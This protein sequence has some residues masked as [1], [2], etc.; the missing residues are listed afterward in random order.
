[1]K[2]PIFETRFSEEIVQEFP[3]K[4]FRRRRWPLYVAGSVII[5]VILLGIAWWQ[6]EK[7]VSMLW[8]SEKLQ[9]S[10]EQ[11]LGTEPLELFGGGGRGKTILLIGADRRSG[12]EEKWGRSDTIIVARILPQERAISLLSLPRDLQVEI[13]GYGFDKINAAYSLG[14]P[15][16]LIETVRN[17]VGSPIDHYVE[18][19]FDGFA[20]MVRETDGVYLPVDRDYYHSNEG[21]S[22]LEMYSE[23]DIDPGY[24]KLGAEDALAFVRYRHTDSDFLRAARQQLFLRELA[25]QLQQDLEEGSLG[26]RM[27][28]VEAFLEETRS[29]IRSAREALSIGQTVREIPSERI[30]RVVLQANSFI[31]NGVFYVSPT[32]EQKEEA[33]E[34]WNNPNLFFRKGTRSRK[35]PLGTMFLRGTSWLVRNSQ[36]KTFS[37]PLQQPGAP[38]APVVRFLNNWRPVAF[39]TNSTFA[40][41]RRDLFLAKASSYG[42]KSS[43]AAEEVPL[44]DSPAPDLPPSPLRPC[45]PS[46]LPEGYSWGEPREYTLEGRQAITL[47]AEKSA[48]SGLLWNWSSWQE[49]PILRSPDEKVRIRKRLF[50]LW[51][52][53]GVPRI[54]AWRSGTGYGWVHNTLDNALGRKDM[55]RLA[56]ACN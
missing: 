13:P 44:V 35:T 9:N 7:I 41:L 40:P 11:S 6:E 24:Q 28:L 34:K 14:G 39:A 21:L 51:T 48:S 52:D 32:A 36:S 54:I 8:P 25:R 23:I 4:T 5:F 16:K 50:F 31:S 53:S 56:R 55:L 30:V 26:S 3:R 10:A 1:M 20:R 47:S 29:D 33:L 19:D 2:P 12:F 22:E 45:Q 37:L 38:L 17:F 43:P 42:S 27:D 49:A 46:L 15:Q 18:I